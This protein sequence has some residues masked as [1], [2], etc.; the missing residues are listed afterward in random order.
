[1][2]SMNELL[3][4]FETSKLE[5]MLE[6]IESELCRRREKTITGRFFVAELN[7]ANTWIHC[8]ISLI[9]ETACGKSLPSHYASAPIIKIDP[10]TDSSLPTP[11]LMT[12]AKEDI[13]RY[14]KSHTDECYFIDSLRYDPI[15]MSFWVSLGDAEVWKRPSRETF[16]SQCS[17]GV[18]V[19]AGI[20]NSVKASLAARKLREDGRRV[21]QWRVNKAR[22]KK[23][24]EA[25]EASLSEICIDVP[26]SQQTGGNVYLMKNG[27]G[28][29]K[30]GMTKKKPKHRESTLQS[31]EPEVEL[32]YHGWVDDPYGVE[33]ELHSKYADKRLRGEWFSL[34]AKDIA[35]AKKFIARNED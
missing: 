1:M 33:R 32:I 17:I 5:A 25:R 10:P 15:A 24:Q 31:Q 23:I 22:A 8:V 6:N 18:M 26:K 13:E 35:Y 19:K 14:V 34:E 9:R 2:V 16:Q 27:F 29:I 7:Y 30:I 12:E 21:R 11:E 4:K 20:K 3:K 28:H